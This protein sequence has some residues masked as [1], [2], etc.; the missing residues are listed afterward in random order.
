M[1]RILAVTESECLT[2]KRG[3]KVR[4]KGEKRRQNKKVENNLL[5]ADAQIVISGFLPILGLAIAS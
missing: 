1:E 4:L 3:G 2:P 5:I